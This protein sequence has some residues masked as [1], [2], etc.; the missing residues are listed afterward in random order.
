[1]RNYQEKIVFLVLFGLLSNI[2]VIHSQTN[3]NDT[4][5]YNL[6]DNAT[7]KNNLPFYNGSRHVNYYRTLDGSHS[8]YQSG[9]YT[10]G[11][12]VFEDQPY[13]D[14]DLKYDVNND[15]LVFKPVGKFDYLGIN[16]IKEK[17]A[18]FNL[19]NK[20]FVNINYNNPTCPLYMTGYYQEIVFSKSTILYIK[21]HKNRT[22]VID[23][24]SISDGVNQNTTDRFKENNEFILKFKNNYYKINSK[25]EIIKIF[26]EFKSQI[27]NYYNTHIAL[28]ESD[29]KLFIENLIKE[30]NSLLP[31]ESN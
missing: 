12:I 20:R 21:H 9:N 4:S 27:K 17:T 7:G 28:E 23:T 30:I 19:Y 18:S 25:N 3:N 14:V 10:T 5:I 1:M 31:N 13:Y 16:V 11:S 26:P 24:Q 6:F 29:N 22:K 15:I 8:Y 2:Y